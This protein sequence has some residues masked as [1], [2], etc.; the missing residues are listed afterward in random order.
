MIYRLLAD[1]FLVS[2][3]GFVLFVVFGGLLVL[4]RRWIL[5]LHLPALTWGVV[6]EFLQINCPLTSLENYFR[7]LGGQ[8][9]YEGGFIEY[10]VF[11]LLYW[12][13]TPQ[14]QMLLGALLLAFNLIIY[15]FIF[16]QTRTLVRK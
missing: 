10:F 2:H 11:A 8:A 6:I 14:S 7:A 13:L 15:F 9:G 16:R 3:F 1:F 5:W 4:W 12:Q